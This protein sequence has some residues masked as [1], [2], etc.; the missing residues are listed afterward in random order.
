MFQKKVF[1]RKLFDKIAFEQ[2]IQEDSNFET[3]Q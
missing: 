2:D 1:Y 3:D